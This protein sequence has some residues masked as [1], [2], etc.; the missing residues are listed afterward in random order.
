MSGDDLEGRTYTHTEV[1]GHELVEG[2]VVTLTKGEARLV[3]T[4]CAG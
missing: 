1:R 2:T 3:L 4:G